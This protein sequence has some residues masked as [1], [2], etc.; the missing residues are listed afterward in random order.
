MQFGI[1]AGYEMTG[2]RVTLLDGAY[3]RGRLL[4]ARLQDRRFAGLQGG[5]AQGQSPVLLE[6]MMAVEVTTPED[7]MGDVI[8]GTS[9]PAVARS[10]PW[11]SGRVPA[12]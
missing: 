8:G 7:Y 5:R 6:P 10:R 2:V 4:R 12:S 11:R 1:L 3:H 9:T